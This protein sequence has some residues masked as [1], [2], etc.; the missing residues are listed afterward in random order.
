M[1]MKQVAA[2]LYTLRD[3]LKTPLEIAKTLRRVRAMSH[4]GTCP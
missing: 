2:Q 4:V 1:R 3:H